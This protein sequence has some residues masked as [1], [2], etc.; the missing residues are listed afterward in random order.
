M[1]D[2]FTRNLVLLTLLVVASVPATAHPLLGDANEAPPLF[3]KNPEPVPGEYIVMLRDHA[4]PPEL[5][6]RVVSELLERAGGERIATFRHG[7]RGFAMRASETAAR[8]LLAD[9]RVQLIEENARV[10]LSNVEYYTD[11]ERWH[12]NRIDQ[13]PSV[14]DHFVN[15]FGWTYD[16]SGTDVYVLDTGIKASHP[17]FA[18]G[19]VTNGADYAGAD[20]HPA[21]NPCGGY[22]SLNGGHGT[23]V[24]SLIGGQTVG[25]ARGTRLIPV[26]FAECDPNRYPWTDININL[27]GGVWALDW[28]LDQLRQQHPTDPTERRPSV[29]NMSFYYNTTDKCVDDRDPE[30]PQEYDCA[31]AL[32]NNIWNLLQENVVVVAS[33]NNQNTNACS[34]QSPAR[35]G[36]GGMYDDPVNDPGRRLVITVAGTDILDRHY[37]TGCPS[38]AG[39]NH[40]ACVNIYAPAESVLSARID[41]YRDRMNICESSGTSF[42]APLV[43]GAAAR[44]LQQNPNWNPRQVWNYM[45]GQAT[46]L[47]NFLDPD[48]IPD[49]NILLYMSTYW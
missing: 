41:G 48:S 43:A 34:T 25:Q 1:P 21:T 18:T 12:L 28:I 39:S 5:I 16:G 8:R 31:P 42:A 26:K 29:V 20:G 23:S 11:N 45:R 19:Q 49:N 9:S 24:A 13:R 27:I 44:L 3:K 10:H 30:N 14:I 46:P 32:E 37:V 47:S 33:A 36:Y 4:V 15:S 40:G 35:M 38:N 6:D 22:D 7:L 2:H 17:E